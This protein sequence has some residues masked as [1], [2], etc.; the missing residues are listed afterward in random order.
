MSS[1]SGSLPGRIRRDDVEAAR[2]AAA[3]AKRRPAP[4]K[5]TAPAKPGLPRL[6]LQP[7]QLDLLALGLVA[8]G[9]FLAA[10]L[11]ADVAGGRLGDALTDGLRWLVGLLAYAAPAALVVAGGVVVGRDLVPAMRPVRTGAIC[12]LLGL[13]P[14]LAAGTFGLGPGDPRPPVLDPAGFT[15]RGG[16]LGDGMLWV[17]T[18]LVSEIG[19]DIAAVFL[20]L[21]AALLLSGATVAGVVR[22]AHTSV[23]DTSRALRE[24][25]RAQ[26]A[27]GLDDRPPAPPLLPPEPAGE[28]LL[29]SAPAWDDEDDDEDEQP[30]EPEPEAVEAEDATLVV[31]APEE[32]DDEPAPADETAVAYAEDQ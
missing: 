9:V 8:A 3:R 5:K 21:A 28:E 6:E 29:V 1:T 20:L 13:A 27:L 15:D 2:M 16:A 22:T 23:T 31:P 25:T 14:A 11:W 32:A 10:V 4:K 17:L 7:H 26:T 19:A 12:L 18:Q 24:K 30:W